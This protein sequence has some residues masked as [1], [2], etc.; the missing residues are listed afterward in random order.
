M[1]DAL[2]RL[3]AKPSV[4]DWGAGVASAGTSH[5]FPLVGVTTPI[6]MRAACNAKKWHREVR[7]ES[8]PS[9]CG[10]C[11]RLLKRAKAIEAARRR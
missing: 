6:D 2:S 9:T 4:Y 7:A 3:L 10:H 1:S 11:L 5:L 8:N